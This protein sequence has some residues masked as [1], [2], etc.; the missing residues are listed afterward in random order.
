MNKYK[1]VVFDMD[2]VI[3]KHKNFWMHLHKVL[4]TYEEGKA[5]TDKLLRTDYPKLVEEVVG[6][7]W[8]GKD[9]TPYF[10]LIEE[11]QYM[12]GADQ[13]LK[14]LKE[15]GYKTAIISSG[16]RHAALRAQEECGVDYIHTHDLK[17]GSDNTFTGFYE[18]DLGDHDKTHRLKD[19]VSQTG[20]TMAETV[21]VGHDHNDTSSLK[22]AGLGIAVN[23]E[24]DSVAKA[25]D[26]TIP[27][28]KQLMQTIE[29]Q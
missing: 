28:I 26:I 19:F 27:E 2:G 6:R 3:F 5:L 22:A 24:N 9:A 18:W 20:C 15:K 12:E 11:M 21:F 14:L 23:P 10:K 16:P 13:A 7:L 25:A 8:K 1:L 17:I 29:A 4:G